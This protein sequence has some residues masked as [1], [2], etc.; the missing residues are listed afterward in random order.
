MKLTHDLIE[1]KTGLRIRLVIRT[2]AV[3]GLP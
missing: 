3:G 1:R 2:G